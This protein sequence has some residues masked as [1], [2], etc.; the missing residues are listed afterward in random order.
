MF[1][2]RFRTRY[3]LVFHEKLIGVA[4]LETFTVG[5]AAPS[6]R[7]PW[8][9]AR[10][11]DKH[12]ARMKSYCKPCSGQCS[13][14][15]ENLVQNTGDPSWRR[16]C[17]VSEIAQPSPS[18]V[19]SDQQIKS[20]YFTTVPLRKGLVYPRYLRWKYPIAIVRSRLLLALAII[21]EGNI[22]VAQDLCIVGKPQT[23]WKVCVTPRT[24]YSMHDRK[25]TGNAEYIVLKSGNAT[26]F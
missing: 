9:A 24:H 2:K 16:I 14:C 22:I 26:I 7:R 25:S 18:L 13:Q 15:R 10:K 8:Y 17:P 21:N 11:D 6:C 23:S 12:A 4:C 3:L 20:I 19:E 1:V 5:P